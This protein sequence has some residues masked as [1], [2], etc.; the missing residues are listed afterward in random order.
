[1]VII[2]VS[3]TSSFKFDLFLDE[4]KFAKGLSGLY[5]MWLLLNDDNN[6]L[7]SVSFSFPLG[8]WLAMARFFLRLD[9]FR[10]TSPRIERRQQQPKFSW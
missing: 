3:N 1:M 8:F 4:V 9:N 7:F 5:A 10:Y 6:E 2:I